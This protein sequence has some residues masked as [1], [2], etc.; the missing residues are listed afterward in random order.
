MWR[1]YVVGRLAPEKTEQNQCSTEVRGWPPYARLRLAQQPASLALVAL[2]LTLSPASGVGWQF[3]ATAKAR[4][5]S[6]TTEDEKRT[7]LL[8][9]TTTSSG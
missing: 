1:R 3:C 8:D 4:L 7:F 9:H 6:C 2:S 5:Q